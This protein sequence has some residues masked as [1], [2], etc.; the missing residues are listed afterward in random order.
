MEH[1]FFCFLKVFFK[2]EMITTLSVPKTELLGYQVQS[3]LSWNKA[4]VLSPAIMNRC[5]CSNVL[6]TITLFWFFSECHKKCVKFEL[7]HHNGTHKR[8]IF[9]MSV[10]TNIATLKFCMCISYRILYFIC[11]ICLHQLSPLGALFSS[12]SVNICENHRFFYFVK[13][14]N[15]ITSSNSKIATSPFACTCCKT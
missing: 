4:S 13:F 12:K 2:S 5:I 7:F 8:G 9:D 14:E 10:K 11:S 15:I 1:Y 3:C 6:I